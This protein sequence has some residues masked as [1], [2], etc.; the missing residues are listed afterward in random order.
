M[1][2]LPPHLAPQPQS[3]DQG[4][5]LI[6]EQ[7]PNEEEPKEIVAHFNPEE[8]HYLDETM[9]MFFP[10][11]REHPSID[12]QTG[13]RDYRPLDNPQLLELI[14]EGFAQERQKFAMGGEVTEEGRPTI[15]NWKN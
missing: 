6:Q 3:L 9:G 14:S 5:P 12:P 7:M 15:Q 11:F 8:L 4:M 2:N 1:H 13:L 10:E